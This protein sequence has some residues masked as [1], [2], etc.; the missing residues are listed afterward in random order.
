MTFSQLN[1]H[2]ALLR[3]IE[4]MG[5]NQPTAIQSEAIPP[6]LAGHDVLACAMTGSGKTAAFLLPILQRLLDEPR[7]TT[8][9]LILTPTRELATQIQ[10]HF[11]Q[12][13][14]HTRL[15]SAVIMGGV[16]AAPQIRALKSGVE[17]LI[18][19]P[20]RLLDHLD[21]SYTRLS[22]LE[23]LVLDEA[24]RMLDMG[25]LPAIRQVLSHLPARRQTLFFS[26]TMPRPIARLA[27]EILKQP[28]SINQERQAAP[29]T[30]LTQSAYPVAQ[31]LKARLLLQLIAHER[32]RQVIVFTRTKHRANR[33][34]ELLTAAGV[35]CDRIHGNRTQAQ[36][37]QALESFKS[38]K[39]QVLVATDIAA[40]GL[41]IEALGHVVNFDVPQVAEDYI[42]RVGRTARAERT[43]DAITFVAPDEEERWRAIERAIGK[44]LP[45]LTLA[46]FDY[47]ATPAQP[48]EVPIRERIAAIRSA[49]TEE[50]ARA[51]AKAERKAQRQPA[52]AH[53]RPEAKRP[54]LRKRASA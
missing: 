17:V 19:T 34:A 45:R 47:K 43:G 22:G 33:L 37:T 48:L 35:S 27:R 23:V 16:P 8:R 7:G 24:D 1:L 21:Q 28:F 36:R 25:F 39:C 26:A 41:D 53:S 11:V 32:M 3:G 29:A 13:A 12:L 38:G 51:T 42:H 44:R 18:A 2:L 40:R 14:R 5:F 30:G 15:R 49:K 31:E 50:R 9:A 4:E 54:A 10:E 52:Q 46:G 6:A 20:G